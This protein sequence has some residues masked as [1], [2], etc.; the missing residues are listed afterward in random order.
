MN[1]WRESVAG[2]A[3]FGVEFVPMEFESM[4]FRRTLFEVGRWPLT[5]MTE[6]PRPNSVLFATLE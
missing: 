6:S 5:V 1:S 4:P 3:M 2:T